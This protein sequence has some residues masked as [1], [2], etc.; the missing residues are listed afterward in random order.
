MGVYAHELELFYTELLCRWER[1]AGK[2]KK[3]NEWQFL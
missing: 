3:N 1:A 2:K